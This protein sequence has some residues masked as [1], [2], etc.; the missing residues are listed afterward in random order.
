MSFASGLDANRHIQ[1]MYLPAPYNASYGQFS[2]TISQTVSGSNTATPLTYNRTDI[3]FGVYYDSSNNSRIYVSSG[4]VYK[5]A[6]SIQLDKTGGGT[7]VV[8]IWIAKNGD[9]VEWTASRATVVGQN[10]ET[11]VYTEFLVPL[12]IGDYIEFK[13]ISSD[14]TMTAQSFVSVGFPSVPS[15]IA[16]IIQIA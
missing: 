16:T 15:I 5:C 10:G 12:S 3:S 2:S 1:R 6:F 4:G 7:N 8:D 9:D 14:A 11:F 13:F